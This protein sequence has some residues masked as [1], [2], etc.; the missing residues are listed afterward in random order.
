MRPYR[1]SSSDVGIFR[2]DAAISPQRIHHAGRGF[3]VNQRDGIELSGRQLPIDCLRIDVLAPFDLQRLGVLAAPLRDI[4]PFVRKR[5]AHAAEHAA[6]DQIADR[7]F[8][9]APGRGRGKKHRLLRAEQLLKLRMNRA[10]KILEIVAAMADHRPRKC[11]PGFFGN[12]DRTGNESLSC[13]CMNRNI[14]HP[15]SNVQC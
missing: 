4:E 14:Q 7:G 12:F 8:H 11:R 2:Q 13:G 6:I 15:T 3:I 5:A 10:V 9:H 1:R